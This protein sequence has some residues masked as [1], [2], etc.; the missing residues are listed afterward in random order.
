MAWVTAMNSEEGKL[1]ASVF[2][3]TMSPTA[4]DSNEVADH[5]VRPRMCHNMHGSMASEVSL[6]SSHRTNEEGE[7]EDHAILLPKSLLKPAPR[8]MENHESDTYVTQKDNQVELPEKKCNEMGINGRLQ[9]VDEDTVSVRLRSN[10]VDLKVDN[11]VDSKDENEENDD[12]DEFGDFVGVT[13]R[14]VSESIA[15]P[16]KPMMERNKTPHAFIDQQEKE[17]DHEEKGEGEG[18]GGGTSESGQSN[19][20]ISHTV[21]YASAE[22]TVTTMMGSPEEVYVDTD[23][24]DR[25][26]VSLAVVKDEGGEE[27][28]EYMHGKT[29]GVEG[30][31][32]DEGVGKERE[33][34]HHHHHKNNNNNNQQQKQQ[35]EEEE[36]A[37][38]T[39]AAVPPN[40]SLQTELETEREASG[41]SDMCAEKDTHAVSSGQPFVF[42]RD[43]NIARIIRQ[44]HEFGGCVLNTEEC[45][46]S[47]GDDIEQ[48]Q[49]QQESGIDIHSSSGG[50]DRK[51]KPSRHELLLAV[52]D[53]L[54]FKRRR[55]RRR[56]HDSVNRMQEEEA[57]EEDTPPMGGGSCVTSGSVTSH[58]HPFGTLPCNGEEEGS[59]RRHDTPSPPPPPPPQQ[60]QKQNNNKNNGNCPI[61]HPRR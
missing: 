44:L 3:A 21:M 26:N 24:V 60:K 52:M 57:E 2:G 25:I 18:E 9:S 40:P 28:E 56:R 36:W 20:L 27:A 38:F 6:Q 29:N 51:E 7:E 11:N 49:E 13:S 10:E 50:E 53:A 42:R 37:A 30:R 46:G 12:D 47:H 22:P 4:L 1:K 23:R 41:I 61:K 17:H 14:P 39:D 31:E 48:Q 59:E 58:I 19:V 43:M 5:N 55:R 32:D 35:D 33:H 15:I 34:H 16:A 8:E 54:S 45:N